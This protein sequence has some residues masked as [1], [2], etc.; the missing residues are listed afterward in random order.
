MAITTKHFFAR[1]GMFSQSGSHMLE[2][3]CL[4]SS[5]WDMLGYVVFCLVSSVWDMLY[6]ALFLVCGI[7]CI[8]PCF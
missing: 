3:F 6:F 4:V 2:L 1:N 5:V 8:L 7:C